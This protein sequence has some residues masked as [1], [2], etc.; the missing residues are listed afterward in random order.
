M[1]SF[2]E[3]PTAWEKIKPK[4]RNK[5]STDHHEHVEEQVQV[6][7]QLKTHGGCKDSQFENHNESEIENRKVCHTYMKHLDANRKLYISLYQFIVYSDWSPTHLAKV[8]IFKKRFWQNMAPMDRI[9]RVSFNVSS[10]VESWV[11]SSKT[12]PKSVKV[13]TSSIELN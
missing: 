13:R 7:D 10:Q 12:S 4:Q 2:E 8:G 6:F 11:E 9:M 5:V 3:A 1:F